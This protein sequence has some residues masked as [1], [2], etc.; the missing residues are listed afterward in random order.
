MNPIDFACTFQDPNTLQL[1]GAQK[2]EPCKFP[3]TR[4]EPWKPLLVQ[5]KYLCHDDRN[6]AAA[7]MNRDG[8]E[9][10]DAQMERA[11][12]GSDLI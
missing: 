5:G 12:E 9:V 11:I 6:Q 3:V 4:F 1:C 10:S 8:S 2:G 7:A